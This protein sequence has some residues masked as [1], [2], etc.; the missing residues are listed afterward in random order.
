MQCYQFQIGEENRA[1]G[2]LKSIKMSLSILIATNL[3]IIGEKNGEQMVYRKG[4]KKCHCQSSSPKSSL[5]HS[6]L[7]EFSH[8]LVTFITSH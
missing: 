4:S 2:I 3:K 6:F 8:L 5:Y 7:S 1:N